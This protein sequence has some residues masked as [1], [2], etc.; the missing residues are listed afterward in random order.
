[1][2]YSVVK[3]D[4]G[5]WDYLKEI[6]MYQCRERASVT[7]RDDKGME[8]TYT[9][10]PGFRTDG[11]SVPNVFE[12]VIK[13]WYDDRPLTN[14]AFCV[15]DANYGMKYM[16]KELSD[17]LLRGM[18]RD[19]GHSRLVASTVCWCVKKFAKSHYGV[20]DLGNECFVQFGI[21]CK[22]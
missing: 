6:D 13:G 21:K 9:F 3:Y 22:I 8:L 1:M 4:Y 5:R 19:D 17:D 7:V 15:H 11:G 20:D 12:W 2:T 18:L 10:L 14:L 16:S